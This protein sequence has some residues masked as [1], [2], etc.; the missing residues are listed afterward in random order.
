[1]RQARTSPAIRGSPFEGAP[2][3][4]RPVKTDPD[5]Q[6]GR[7]GFGLPSYR[8]FLSRIDSGR[9]GKYSGAANGL[10]AGQYGTNLMEVTK[11]KSAKWRKA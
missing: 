8:V 6:R 3:S 4:L 7:K 10:D 5:R 9:G 11:M 2:D 1:M